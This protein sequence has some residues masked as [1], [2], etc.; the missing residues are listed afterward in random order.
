MNYPIQRFGSEII[1]ISQIKKDGSGTIKVEQDKAKA[2]KTGIYSLFRLSIDK[3]TYI[4]TNNNSYY[5]VKLKNSPI[6]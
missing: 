4:A 1:F 2:F 6:N 5:V 3:D